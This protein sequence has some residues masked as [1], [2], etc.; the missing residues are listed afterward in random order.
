M[1]C[2]TADDSFGIC[3]EERPETARICRLGS[4]PR[5]PSAAPSVQRAQ[6]EVGWFGL[7][8][9]DL[10]GDAEGWDL[11]LDGNGGNSALTAFL[12]PP[13][14]SGRQKQV[15]GDCMAGLCQ[16]G[17][18]GPYKQ[19][20]SVRVGGTHARRGCLVPSE[21]NNQSTVCTQTPFGPRESSRCGPHCESHLQRREFREIRCAH[22]AGQGD[23]ARIHLLPT[24]LGSRQGVVLGSE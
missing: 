17:C 7:S 19:G 12:A 9:C 15:H 10:E 16:V 8:I 18:P 2:R 3:R 24:F 11:S 20:V 21:E 23:R 6:G 5:K 22:P 14:W 13:R 4:C 1:L